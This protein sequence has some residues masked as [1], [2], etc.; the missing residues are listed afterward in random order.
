MRSLILYAAALLLSLWTGGCTKE[1]DFKYGSVAPMPVIEGYASSDG[2][3]V[4]LTR[5]REVADSSRNH[6]VEGAYVMVS[7]ADGGETVLDGEGR[8][9]YA[10][11]SAVFAPGDV[12]SLRVETD[13]GVFEATDT[14][15]L[16]P[17]G[18]DVSFTWA[19]VLGSETVALRF[20][21]M[22]PADSTAY[23]ALVVLRNGEVYSW[24][25]FN[26][27][28]RQ[29]GWIEGGILCFNR[30]DLEGKDQ[31]GNAAR[32]EIVIRDGDR[33]EVC[34]VGL[35]K[36][37]YDYLN[38]L[39]LSSGTGANPHGVFLGDALG[40]FAAVGVLRLPAIVFS[41]DSIPADWCPS[42]LN[43]SR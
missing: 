40:L 16:P 42:R 12:C 4:C 37:A 43:I 11:A 34:F 35:S 18:A 30:E 33:V 1:L 10:S 15:A 24:N 21:L 20:G 31:A 36:R 25:V 3:R 27:I 2:V 26:N 14:M 38:A 5:S 22:T 32:P 8:G 29:D 19:E 6:F 39:T 9:V 7:G 17:A 13:D 41:L 28:T 23:Y